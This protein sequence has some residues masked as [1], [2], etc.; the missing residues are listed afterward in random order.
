MPLVISVTGQV[1]VDPPAPP[2]PAPRIWR[3]PVA[4]TWHAWDGTVWDLTGGSSGVWVE[5][6]TRG[7][8]MPDPAHRWDEYPTTDGAEWSGLRYPSREFASVVCVAAGDPYD[9]E[10][11]QSTFFRTLHPRKVGYITARRAL[12]ETRR[13]LNC[14]YVDGA[15]GHPANSYF[16]NAARFGW[17][18]L[19]DPLWSGDPVTATFDNSGTTL[20]YIATTGDGWPPYGL[21][22]ARNISSATVTN[23]GD[24]AAWSVVRFNGPFDSVTL[25]EDGGAGFIEIPVPLAEGQWVEIDMRPGFK[26]VLD[27]AGVNRRADITSFRPFPLPAGESVPLTLSVAGSGAATSV[28]VSFTPL[29][30]AA[31]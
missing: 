14:R 7:T 27:H 16:R 19:A 10:T 11:L 26:T 3:T 21:V 4:L 1:V 31:W 9:F 22:S 28:V 2:P 25:T 5:D 13:L 8:G 12:G 24:E 20:A 29:Y 6:V 23:A 17:R 18:M 30:H 15:D